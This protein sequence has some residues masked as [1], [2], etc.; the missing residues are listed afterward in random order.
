MH[1]SVQNLLN[2]L[3]IM[4]MGMVGIFVVTGF[5]ILSV[6]VLNNLTQK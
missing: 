2:A 6:I 4:G 3:P 1:I 5:I